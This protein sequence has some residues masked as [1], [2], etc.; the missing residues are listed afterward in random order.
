[1][2][3]LDDYNEPKKCDTGNN[4][5]SLQEPALAMTSVRAYIKLFKKV[6][7]RIKGEGLKLTKFH[8]LLHLVHYICLHG[9]LLNIDG[10]DLRQ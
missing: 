2:V 6:V 8:Q 4:Q 5:S 1:M 10:G 3:P 9:S 7:Q